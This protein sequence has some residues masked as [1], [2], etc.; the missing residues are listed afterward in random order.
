MLSQIIW[1]GRIKRNSLWSLYIQAHLRTTIREKYTFFLPMCYQICMQ[2]TGEWQ[3][4]PSKTD[5]KGWF[6]GN[7][8]IRDL[9]NQ[10]QKPHC[11]RKRTGPNDDM[12]HTDQFSSKKGV[13]GTV[14]FI[15]GL[16]C[17][18]FFTNLKFL[19]GRF[20]SSH[21]I[22]EQTLAHRDL[23]ICLRSAR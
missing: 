20:Y 7:P 18:S 13:E 17:T 14:I 21:S 9:K 10:Y 15:V 22:V 2:P 4:R 23:M 19:L 5:F 11:N 8:E 6:K 1:I 16:L 12:E 3:S